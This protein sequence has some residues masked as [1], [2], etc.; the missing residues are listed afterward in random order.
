MRGENRSLPFALMSEKHFTNLT[1]YLLNPFTDTHNVPHK[2]KFKVNKSRTESYKKCKI[3]FF[4]RRL[5]EYYT[6]KDK[7]DQGRRDKERRR[8]AQ[9]I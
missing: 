2:E 6:K 7:L 8:G 9:I 4:Q 3:L 1:I 5:N